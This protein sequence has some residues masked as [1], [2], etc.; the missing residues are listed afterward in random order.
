MG[1]IVISDTACIR[2]T[3]QGFRKNPRSGQQRIMK[4]LT[5]RRTVRG[6]FAL[7]TP[8][9]GLTMASSTSWPVGRL[10][11][12]LECRGQELSCYVTL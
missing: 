8:A 9:A 10:C 6:I 11:D 3:G 4:R 7:R 5:H 1:Y 12:G 2:K